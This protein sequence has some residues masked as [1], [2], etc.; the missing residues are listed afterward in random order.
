[1][2]SPGKVRVL[3]LSTTSTGAGGTTVSVRPDDGKQYEILYAI[4]YHA[5]AAGVV[6]DWVFS[7]PD[8]GG[9]VGLAGGGITI[10]PSVIHPIGAI[11]SGGDT[12]LLG[13]VKATRG[14]YPS[15]VFVASAINKVGYV[16]ALVI[17][18]SGTLDG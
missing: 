9:A 3:S 8:S 5:D 7:D 17:E 16:R 13:P 10:N 1:M 11:T 4:G 12:Q 6:C 14:R 15:F 18:Y 2:I